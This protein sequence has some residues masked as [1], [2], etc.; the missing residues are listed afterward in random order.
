MILPVGFGSEEAAGGYQIERSLRFNS[1]DSAYLE[2][3]PGSAATSRRIMTYSAWVKIGTLGTSKLLYEGYTSVSDY[4]ALQFNSSNQLE[5]QAQVNGGASYGVRTPALFR[6]PSAWYHV[7]I[8]IDTTQATDTNRIKIYVNGVQQTGLTTFYSGFPAQNTDLEWNNQ[9]STQAIGWGGH[10]GYYNGYMTEIHMVDGQTLDPTSFGEYNEDTG[11][12]Q[13]KAY[14]G[15]YGTNGFY[16]NFS[17]NSDVT[18]A[19]LGADS[20]GNGNNWTPNV[21]V[22]SP[23]TSADNDSLVDTPT[24]YGTDTGVGGEVR[25]NYCTLNPLANSGI[26]TL[27]EGNLKLVT[28]TNSK[29]VTATMALPSTGQFYF[30]ITATDYASGGGTFL[31]LVNNSFLTGAPSN[32]TWLGFNTYSGS[33]S[34]GTTTDTNGLSGTDVTNDDDIWCVAVDMTN[35]KFWI[36]RSRSGSLT[37]ADGTTPAVNGSGATTLALPSGTLYPMAYRGGSFNETYNFNFGQRAFSHAAPTGFKALCT[38]NLPE[39]EATIPNGGEYFNTVLYTGNYAT[40]SITGVGFQPDL[41]WIKRRD[42]AQTFSN[43]V[44]DAVRGRAASLITNITTAEQTSA[45]DKDLTAFTSDGFNLGQSNNVSVNDNAGTYVAWNWKANGAG[46]SNTDGTITSTVSVSTT[47][48]F[49][50][51]TYTGNGSAGATVGHG[52][53]VA[54]SMVIVKE[55]QNANAWCVYHSSIGATKFLRL[56]GTDAEETQTDIWNDTEPSSSAPYVFTVGDAPATNRNA[57]NLVAYCFAAIPGYSAFGKYTGNG[58]TDGPFVYTGFRPAFVIIK[59]ISATGDW[60][61]EDVARSPFNVSTN[62]LM[63]NN[64]NAETTGQLIDFVSNGFKIR[65]AVSSAMNS[66][67]A[68]YIYMAFAENPFKLSLAR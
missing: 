17:D 16:L 55:R 65:V 30:E 22:V 47:S 35:G 24:P 8:A 5:W 59:S 26:G 21:F 62:Y 23:V 64:S 31:G 67:G 44:F 58:S 45:A 28:S 68:T 39:S 10:T 12:W 13:P 29:T 61:I 63:P 40:N 32:G 11:V 66:S 6:D 7:V 56:N 15:S 2:R 48:G 50:I 41:V 19:T 57:N 27:S 42:A 34:N 14:T 25:G 20:S 38:Q 1:A 53:G 36:G 60:I 54:P 49:S 33:Y 43:G 18:A 51:V 46:V 9:S 52:L 4:E 37:W 3:T